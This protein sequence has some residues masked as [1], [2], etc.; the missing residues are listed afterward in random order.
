M[1]TYLLFSGV[2]SM[3]FAKIASIALVSVSATLVCVSSAFA[4]PIS[5]TL[6]TRSAITNTVGCT[7]IVEV[8]SSETTANVKAIDSINL[9]GGVDGKTIIGS[10][11]ET[12]DATTKSR[13]SYTRNDDLQQKGVSV[14]NSVSIDVSVQ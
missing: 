1:F 10:K 8:G 7:T 11:S 13:S 4:G 3:N 9:Y 5:N 12:L 14:V 6:T 2:F